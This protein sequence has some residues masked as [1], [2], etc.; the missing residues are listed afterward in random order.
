MSANLKCV[1]YHIQLFFG[2]RGKGADLNGSA[3]G[4]LVA[5]GAGGA[6][7]WARLLSLWFKLKF[8]IF[9][10]IGPA[11]LEDWVGCNELDCVDG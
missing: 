9:W 2:A 11:T 10:W 6:C 3:H 1:K 5:K 4:L 7:R 8:P